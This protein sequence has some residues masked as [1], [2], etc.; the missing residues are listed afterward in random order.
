MS[1]FESR[2]NAA[3]FLQRRSRN[4]RNAA[5]AI[6]GIV[7]ISTIETVSNMQ[8]TDAKEL[9]VGAVS[10]VITGCGTIALAGCAQSSIESSRWAEEMRA[11]NS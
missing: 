11:E 6:S 10:G 3:Q 4:Y 1:S 7:A 9:L 5:L 8:S 2:Q